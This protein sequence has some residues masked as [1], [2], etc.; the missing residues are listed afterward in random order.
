M[1]WFLR[2]CAFLGILEDVPGFLAGFPGFLG[3]VPS[4]RWCSG[5]LGVAGC[6]GMFRDVP[7][8]LEVLHAMKIRRHR[9]ES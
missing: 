8:F 9:F 2:F 5:F 3:G 7:V 1:I 4:F 6:S